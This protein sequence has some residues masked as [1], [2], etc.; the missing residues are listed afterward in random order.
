MRFIVLFVYRKQNSLFSFES[1]ESLPQISEF[2]I[3]LLHQSNTNLKTW[4]RKP[5][6]EW[7]LKYI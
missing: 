2:W 1:V 4:Y 3:L 6:L 5:E 7:L